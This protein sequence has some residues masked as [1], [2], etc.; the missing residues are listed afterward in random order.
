MD[1]EPERLHRLT[2]LVSLSPDNQFTDE[3]MFGS[4]MMSRSPDELRRSASWDGAKGTSRHKL[5]SRLQ[6]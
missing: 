3:L 5:L 4:L 2:R 1:I 6:R